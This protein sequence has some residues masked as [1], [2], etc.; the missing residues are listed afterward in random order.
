MSREVTRSDCGQPAADELDWADERPGQQEAERERQHDRP[1]RDAD[2]EIARVRVRPLVLG[3]QGLCLG[4]CR[5]GKVPGGDLQIDREL[6]GLG[7]QPSRCSRRGGDR[8]NDVLDAS[9]IG[10]DLPQGAALARGRLEAELYGCSEQ[11]QHA[12]DR[13]PDRAEARRR[14]PGRRPPSVQPCLVVGVPGADGELLAQDGGIGL[15]LLVTGDANLKRAEAFRAQVRL[16]EDAESEQ[17]DD[18]E[19]RSDREERDEQ[20]RPDFRVDTRDRPHDRVLGHA[21]QPSPAGAGFLRRCDG[22]GQGI[23]A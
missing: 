3:D 7:M 8:G 5:L 4:G 1:G 20:L 6:L 12:R 22:F 9:V 11:S 2:E 17:R 14:G 19:Q 13:L 16:A 23:R 15:E 10:P 21:E 18:H